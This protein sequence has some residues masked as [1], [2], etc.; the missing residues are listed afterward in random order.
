MAQVSTGASG[1]MAERARFGSLGSLTFVERI[2][3]AMGAR[4][5]HSGQ[6]LGACRWLPWL[7]ELVGLSL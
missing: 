6:S 4:I 1:G 3:L 5:Q 2:N 7:S